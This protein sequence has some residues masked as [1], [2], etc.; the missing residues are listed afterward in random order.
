MPEVPPGEQLEY[1]SE[2][3]DAAAAEAS[4]ASII[5]SNPAQ[6]ERD[7]QPQEFGAGFV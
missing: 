3:S 2:G 5:H 6:E 4:P 1:L 7:L